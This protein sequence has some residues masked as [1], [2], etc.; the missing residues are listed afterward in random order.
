MRQ[1]RHQR[2]SSGF[3]N[4]YLVKKAPFQLPDGFKQFLVKF[5]PWIALV[6]IV[7]SIP[8]LLLGLG[9]GAVAAVGGSMLLPAIIVSCI[10]LVLRGMALPG[11]FARKMSG[12]K[13]LAYTPNSV[14][15]VSSLIIGAWVS[16]ILGGLISLARSMIR[17]RYR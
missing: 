5:G 1:I 4:Y 9:V 11:L 12:W 6:L 17:A 2:I 16:V 13:L 14:S 8:F 10:S 7:I 3:W 15:M